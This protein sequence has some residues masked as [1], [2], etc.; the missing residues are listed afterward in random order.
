VEFAPTLYPLIAEK[1]SDKIAALKAK[2]QLE[3]S[4]GPS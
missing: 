2:A 3:R 4:V 1:M